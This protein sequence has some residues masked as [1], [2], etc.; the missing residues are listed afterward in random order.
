MA[1]SQLSNFIAEVVLTSHYLVEPMRKTNSELSD[2][3]MRCLKI[4]ST[5][6]PISMQEIASKMYASKPRATQLVAL[7]EAHGMV[8]RAVATDRRRIEVVTAPGGKRAV[9][10]LNQRYEKLALAIEEKLG[11]EDTATLVRLLKQITPL[12]KLDG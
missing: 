9:S 1:N 5:F 7:L 3:E 12:S 8:E 10:Q 4:I 2:A 11:K 6:E